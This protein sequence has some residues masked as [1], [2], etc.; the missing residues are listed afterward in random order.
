MLSKLIIER[1][2]L[3]KYLTNN[4]KK[5]SFV[6]I[7][8][9]ILT[10]Y[11]EFLVLFWIDII[12][13][14]KNFYKIV[15]GKYWK[16]ILYLEYFIIYF[17]ISIL[18]TIFN[19]NFLQ[20]IVVLLCLFCIMIFLDFLINNFFNKIKFKN[21]NYEKIIHNLNYEFIIFIKKYLANL[22]FLN[23]LFSIILIKY[24]FEF[25]FLIY[26][27]ILNFLLPTIYFIQE[28]NILKEIRGNENKVI[29]SKV[30]LTQGKLIL[31]ILFPLFLLNFI[32]LSNKIFIICC[33]LSFFLNFYFLINY[34][35]KY[36]NKINIIKL[37]YYYIFSSIIILLPLFIYL[38]F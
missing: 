21:L 5:E 9:F 1:I 36:F 23:I 28:E 20:N 24:R 30:F 38:L 11:L 27:L 35:Y 33:F 32:I 3:I 12:R 6:F 15:F 17:I 10:F 14:D 25:I 22:I 19:N 7:I 8:L 34:K 16:K 29:C 18:F 37:F 2:K 13:K 31:I 26:L 4:R